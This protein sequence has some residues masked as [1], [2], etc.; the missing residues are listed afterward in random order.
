MRRRYDRATAVMPTGRKRTT[1]GYEKVG[2][3]IPEGL[4]EEEGPR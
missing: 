1:A 4:H 2:V 3:A